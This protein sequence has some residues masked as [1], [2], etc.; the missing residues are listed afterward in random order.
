MVVEPRPYPKF[1]SQAMKNF[2]QLFP[3]LE[4]I[5][6]QRT[7]AGMIDATPDAV[8]VIGE[9]EQPRGLIFATGFSGHGFALGPIAGKLVSEIILDG[10]SSIDLHKMRHS[11][12]REG[13][14]EKARSVV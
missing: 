3:A 7:W 10:K 12:F 8:P 5:R 13:D 14:L 4:N 9:V 6:V 11:R 1:I 2:G